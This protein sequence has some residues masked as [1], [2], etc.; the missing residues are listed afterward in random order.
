MYELRA[1]I[2][3]LTTLYIGPLIVWC[4]RLSR[5]CTKAVIASDAD[6]LDEIGPT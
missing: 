4:F 1:P 2:Q 3:L 6:H 5:I